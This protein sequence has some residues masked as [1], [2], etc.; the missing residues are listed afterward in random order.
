[1]DPA[2]MFD[3]DGRDLDEDGDEP[4]DDAPRHE[5][6]LRALVADEQLPD[7]PTRRRRSRR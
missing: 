5:L 2:N 6:Q 7:E 3:L 1:M 4:D